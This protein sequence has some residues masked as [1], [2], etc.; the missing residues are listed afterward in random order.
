M[1]LLLDTDVTRRRLGFEAAAHLYRRQREGKTIT[2]YFAHQ[3][4]GRAINPALVAVHWDG[5]SRTPRQ[6]ERSAQCASKEVGHQSPLSA[7]F[8]TFRFDRE[9]FLMK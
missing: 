9:R 7:D 4:K 2:K 1:L 8:S 6:S 5:F 3:K